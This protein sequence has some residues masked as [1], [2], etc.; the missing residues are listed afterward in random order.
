[1][2]MIDIEIEDQ[3]DRSRRKA[4]SSPTIVVASPRHQ[5]RQLAVTV[6]DSTRPSRTFVAYVVDADQQPRLVV[7]DVVDAARPVADD[8]RSSKRWRRT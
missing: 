3:S 6:I 8:E 4:L 7:V 5:R 1:M 2:T